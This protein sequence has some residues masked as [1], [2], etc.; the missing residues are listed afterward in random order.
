MKKTKGAKALKKRWDL[1]TNP[2]PNLLFSLTRQKVA[3]IMK[4]KFWSPDPD[5][6]YCFLSHHLRAQNLCQTVEEISFAY[7][8]MRGHLE[9]K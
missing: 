6:P 3:E 9:A 1:F 4:C 5:G 7:W 8:R 2:E